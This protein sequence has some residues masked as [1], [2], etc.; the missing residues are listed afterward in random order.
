VWM[1]LDPVPGHMLPPVLVPSHLR[2]WG[3]YRVAN[4]GIPIGVLLSPNQSRRSTADRRGTWATL[5]DIQDMNSSKN[6]LNLLSV[7]SYADG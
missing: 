2:S 3:G 6:I 1:C 7:S 4:A 5:Q